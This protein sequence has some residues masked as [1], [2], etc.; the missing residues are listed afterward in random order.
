MENS[1]LLTVNYSIF[2]MIQ[3]AFSFHSPL[4]RQPYQDLGRGV[5]IGERRMKTPFYPP[6]ISVSL[7][8][9]SASFAFV[10]WS[11]LLAEK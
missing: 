1:S 10:N 7:A 9:C 6:P 11:K 5:C 4:T 2:E 3:T 8:T